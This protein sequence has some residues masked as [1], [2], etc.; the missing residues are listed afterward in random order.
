MTL[1]HT[2]PNAVEAAYRRY[3]L[4]E[5]RRRLMGAWSQFCAKPGTT[6]DVVPIWARR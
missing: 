6:G 2:I 3:D 5:K 4:F 1:A